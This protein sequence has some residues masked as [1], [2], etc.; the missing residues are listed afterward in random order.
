MS[1][2]QRLA[3]WIAGRQTFDPGDEAICAGDRP[4]TCLRCQSEGPF[5][6]IILLR[7]PVLRQGRMVMVMT[8]ARVACQRCSFVFSVAIPGSFEH[9]LDA[10]PITSGDRRPARSSEPAQRP[11]APEPDELLTPLKKPRV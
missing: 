5:A 11:P 9:H 3:E 2:R 1:L 8:G 7:S 6:E 10:L 4:Y